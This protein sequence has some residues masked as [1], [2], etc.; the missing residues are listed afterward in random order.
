MVVRRRGGRLDVEVQEFGTHE[1][2]AGGQADVDRRVYRLWD[3]TVV[4]FYWICCG[5]SDPLKHR[6]NPIFVGPKGRMQRLFCPTCGTEIP[7]RRQFEER[8]AWPKHRSWRM[9][10]FRAPAWWQRWVRWVLRPRGELMAEI[11][12]DGRSTSVPLAGIESPRWLAP[13]LTEKEGRR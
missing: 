1:L 5:Q 11:E 4:P 9:R 13:L 2:P 3:G 12:Q 8:P 10:L 7:V 6:G